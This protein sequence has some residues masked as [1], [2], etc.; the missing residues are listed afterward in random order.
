LAE[1]IRIKVFPTVQK[2]DSSSE[3]SKVIADLEKNAKKIKVGID[4]KDLLSQI[5]KLKEQIN[6]LSKGTNT[7]GNSKMFQNE[8][9]SAK[10]LISEYKKLISQK[11]K[12]ETQMS[13]QTYKGQAYKSLSKDLTKVNKDIE[14]VGSKIDALNKKTIKSDIT[15]SLTS[16][17]ESTIKKATELGTALENALGKRNLT[18]TQTADLKT[19]QRQLDNFKSSANLEN[20][21][22]ADKP[23]AEM[24]KL[25]TRASELTQAFRKIE[26][27][28]ALAKS[29]RKAE[30]D[31]SILQNK[32]KSLYTKG[33]G[34]N[35]AIDKLFTRAKELSNVNIRINSKTAEAD[36][37]SLNDKI[38]KLDSDYNKLV[39]DMQRN[40]K[41]DVF[42]INV[43]ASMKQLEELRTKFT[44]LGKDTSQIDS[45]KARLE[46][47]NKLTFVQAQEEFSKIKAQISEVSA[48]VPKAT[49]AMARF[50]K[51]MNERASLEK[52]MSKTTNTQSYDVLNKKLQEN[53]SNIKKV[54]SELD[55]IKGKNINPDIT[56][57]LASS[58][59]T[60]QNQA[61]KASQ[62]IDNMFKN[63]NL[64]GDQIK[65]LE[66]LKKEID[67]IKGTKL[68]NI[69]NISN[70]HEH[71][72]TLLGD[73]Q[74]VKT[75]AK[76]ITINSDFN[77]R[78]EA[79]YQKVAQ[80]GQ[81]LDKLKNVKGFLNTT[82]LQNRLQ[83]V[84]AL[85]NSDLKNAKINIDS[86]TATTDLRNL[87]ETIQLV[88]GELRDL[89]A[90]STSAKKSFDF[91]TSV[92]SSLERI[93]TLTKALQSMG[94]DT[95]SAEK[96]KTELSNLAN[97]PLEEAESKLKRL[98]NEINSI[99]KNTT[100]IK[101]QADALKEY[102]KL[103]GQKNSLEKTLSKTNIN[104]QSYQ[105]LSAELE[106]ID[107]RI[108][109]TV[110]LMRNVKLPEGNL[111]SITNFAKEFT[112]IE[113]SVTSLESKLSNVMSKTNIPSSQTGRIQEVKS[114]VDYLKT[115]RLDDILKMDKPYEQISLLISEI[116]RL[117]KE[118]KSIDNNITFSEKLG[119]QATQAKSQLQQLQSQVEI[120]KK[121]KFFGDT[122]NIDNLIQRIKTLSGTKIDLN[123]EAAESDVKRLVASLNELEKEFDEL[124]SKSNVDI[125][126]FNLDT[127]IQTATQRLNELEKKFQSIGKDVAPIRKLKDELQGLG[128][129]SFKEAEAQLRRINSEASKLEKGFQNANRAAKSASTGIS[130]SMKS[131]SKFVS[132]LYSTLSTYSLGNILG[133]QITKGIYA[134]NDTIVE[135]D[136]AFRDMEKVAPAS[137]TGTKQELQEVK[138]MAYETGQQ[139]ARSSVDIINSTASA[140]QLGID[141][142][143]D[144]MQYAK[145]VNMY[146]N[147]AEIDEQT[148]DK[149]IKTI[150]SAYGGVAKS[151][152]PM[153]DKVKG[154]GSA[155]SQLADYMD[156]AN[157]AG[158]C[159]LIAQ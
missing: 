47:L 143:K 155:Y 58:F 103:I 105:L 68:D 17:F 95:S 134:I 139:V 37:V 19:L 156:Q 145:S 48:E 83:Q 63:K 92:N 121:T 67:R 11:N 94:K 57:S 72:A 65:Q 64:T 130:T 79:A 4:D 41:M 104:T 97:V 125:K 85:F 43:S 36:V 117:D 126:G 115:V 71:M 141:N 87:S 39:T 147:V 132:N 100:G 14:S 56:R 30:S 114:M 53:L 154:A 158:E 49:S 20:I 124:K 7:K 88:E 86:K 76:D 28:D 42:K 110:S 2:G 159:K 8:T 50:N 98:N 1:D 135:L 22:K 26:L 35:N 61:T 44:S 6:S 148:A 120:F 81:E 77:T 27:S 146:A 34:N 89:S 151:L 32:I 153:T 23:Y 74:K 142:V 116:Q 78:V 60:L 91:T 45:L 106:K 84:I 21:L 152:K 51:L 73:L 108:E 118:L 96:I 38:K 111:A 62:T 16:S 127:S 40:K 99:A 31:A 123:S 5:T 10:E 66:A 3:L 131:A 140:F 157:Y 122:Q 90:I 12:L 82:D 138:E 113:K 29:I 133:M 46:G 52:Q 54:A 80:L 59:E 24:S 55:S 9:K 75:T 109:A 101:T 150:A 112:N 136:S 25:M 119:N 107:T 102:N 93:N 144:A 70:S 18:G 13:K 33:Y 15:A 137:F 69:L 149:Y 128:K 129:V